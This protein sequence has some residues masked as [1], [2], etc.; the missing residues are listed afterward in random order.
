MKRLASMVIFLAGIASLPAQQ[1]GIAQDLEFIAN[2]FSDGKNFIRWYGHVGRS[3]FVQVSDPANHLKTWHFSTMIE[4]GDDDY[5]SHE[6]IGTAEKGF[7]RLKYTDQVPGPDENL[8]TA[9]FDNDGISNRDEVEPPEGISQT[10]PL[11]PD[12]DGD[13]MPDGWERANGLDPNDAT[14]INGADG[15]PDGDGLSNYDEWW[16]Y[17]DPNNSDTDGDGLSDGDEVHLYDS[18]PW[19]DDSDWDGIN[20]Y[21]EVMVYGTDPSNWDTDGDSLSDG[22]EI[23][24]HFTNPLE[25]DTDGD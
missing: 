23:H 9:D 15:D 2:P 21:D 6:V 8:N 22:D 24:I 5:T 11:N 1:N 12:T 17:V 25:M 20:D 19:C 7:F 4:G 13:G 14:G 10:D 18:C 16:N 3:Y